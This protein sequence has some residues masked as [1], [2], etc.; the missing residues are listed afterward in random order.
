MTSTQFNPIKMQAPTAQS[1]QPLTLKQGQVFHGT[2]KQLFPDQ[3]AEVQVGGHKL[4]AKLETPLKAG[5]AHFFQVTNTAGQTELKIV[6]GPMTGAMSQTEQMN[7]LLDTMNLPKTMEMKQVMAN[8]MKE[9][10]PISKEQ[11]IQAETWMKNLPEGVSKQNALSAMQRMVE[12]K[13]PFTNDVFQAL[14]QGGKTDGMQS[15]L[16][17]LAQQLAQPGGNEVLK[18][19]ILQQMN[20]IAKPFQNDLAGS[21]VARAVQI[22][23]SEHTTFAD[24]TQS[25]NF[26]KQ[27]G[28]LP[29][30]ATLQN[31]QAPQTAAAAQLGSVGQLM[32]QLATAKPEQSHQIAD[33]VRS[34]ITNDSLLSSAQKGELLQLVVRFSQ[35]PPT[36]QTLQTFANQ[37]NQQLVQAYAQANDNQ[38]FSQNRSGLTPKDQLLSL[39]NPSAS[40]QTFVQIANQATQS[41]Q[42]L[43]QSLVTQGDAQIQNNMDAK[44][45]EQ[46]IKTV[47]KGLGVSY[48]AALASKGGNVQETANQLKP[49][50][51]ALVQ[52]MQTPP[53]M[54]EA[55][56][57]VLA[58]MNGMQLLS[59]EN[60]H[61]HQLVMQVPL[62]FFGKRMDA[63]LQWNGRMKDD[64]KIDANYARVLF[65]LNMES[66]QQ[67]VIDMQVQNRI[68]TINIF[69][70]EADLE[71]I[72]EPMKQILKAGLLEKEY[73]LSG[74]FIKPF[75]KKNATTSTSKQH[76]G[77]DQQ[78]V[79]IRV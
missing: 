75:E 32:Q 76:N 48:E 18:G 49:Q 63:T 28:A 8:F 25:L 45:M 68:V 11:L 70:N 50:L 36:A 66:I 71:R 61:Q 10:L 38:M 31:W 26:L 67:T 52:D 37:L 78:G 3:M 39:L 16:Q 43:I 21:V 69:N 59:A 56:E 15:V 41:T 33:Q 35:L 46:A 54:R 14:V 51:L 19:S 7:K 65:Y 20:A 17:Q 24:K 4:V 60:G 9:Q 42:P 58:R 79:D 6:S 74:V 27:T 5:D 77:D 12:L 62:E 30:N 47:L 13:M 73:Q 53:V 55:A 40:H 44:A 2:I 72:A 22:L 34:F 29:S 1:S 23:S 57:T 64:G